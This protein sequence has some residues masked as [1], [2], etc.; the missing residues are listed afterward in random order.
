MTHPAPSVTESTFARVVQSTRF[1]SRT[2]SA[3]H[4]LMVQRQAVSDVAK[5]FQLRTQ[6]VYAIRRQFLT[7]YVR[8]LGYPSDWIRA[9]VIAPAQMLD[10]FLADVELERL[11]VTPSA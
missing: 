10:A 4:A 5:A 7:A 8:L 2:K 6:R 3:A 11:K 9:E 1:T